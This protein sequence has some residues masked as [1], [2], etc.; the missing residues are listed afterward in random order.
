MLLFIGTPSRL[1]PASSICSVT[2]PDIPSA[3][4]SPWDSDFYDTDCESESRS[5]RTPVNFDSSRPR[6][7][8]Q[9]PVNFDSFRPQSDRQTPVNYDLFRP[10]SDRLTPVNYDSSRPRSNS[11]TPVNFDAYLRPTDRQTLVHFSSS[12]QWSD[13]QKPV[14]FDPYY[15]GS[16]RQTPVHFDS[17]RSPSARQTPV[18]YDSS[19]RS[20][21]KNQYA[22]HPLFTEYA[23]QALLAVP[24]HKRT[25]LRSESPGLYSPSNPSTL[26]RYQETYQDKELLDRSHTDA[27]S[28]SIRGRS[29]QSSHD[30]FL[31]RLS[32][33]RSIAPGSRPVT[34]SVDNTARTTSRVEYS[35]FKTQN[36][37]GGS[38]NFSPRSNF[39]LGER[40]LPEHDVVRD[41][42]G[43][44]GQTKGPVMQEQYRDRSITPTQT[45]QDRDRSSALPESTSYQTGNSQILSEPAQHQRD[46]SGSMSA[47]SYQ[48]RNNSLPDPTYNARDRIATKVGATVQHARNISIAKLDPVRSLSRNNRT[49]TPESKQNVTRN[50]STL[51]PDDPPGGNVVPNKNFLSK[52]PRSS[53]HPRYVKKPILSNLSSNS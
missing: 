43:Q 25:P 10:R 7:N 30:A 46:T 33:D 9:T 26:P 29:A 45:Y 14:N 19:G 49:P 42:R 27:Y 15:P 12:H 2:G 3:P 28:A 41:T 20:T 31:R 39:D 1:S 36:G 40:E 16:N 24:P 32:L 44:I 47:R 50:S 48:T 52:P 53:S 11:Q 23:N 4:M 8:S 5:R 35:E 51:T 38:S 22:D 6:S 13:Q 37:F 34:P 17:S 18:N 21:P